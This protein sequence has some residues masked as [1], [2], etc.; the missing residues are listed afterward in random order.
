MLPVNNQNKL[1]TV[2]ASNQ[3]IINDI[4]AWYPE[5]LKQVKQSGFYKKFNYGSPIKD[6]HAVWLFLR[7]YI[8]YKKDPDEA[9]LLRLPGRFVNDRSGD[10]KSYS[11]FAAAVMGALGYK[12]GFRYAAYKDGAQNPTHVYIYLPNYDIII[13]GCYRFFNKEKEYKFVKNYIMNNY[14]LSGINSREERRE[15]RQE[16]RER[17]QER[18]EERQERREERKASGKPS[19]FKKI[20][21]AA[22]RN[23]FLLM[24]K[25]NVFGMA[26]KLKLAISKNEKAVKSKWNKLGGNFDKLKKQIEIGAKKKAIL[27]GKNTKLAKEQIEGI[28]EYVKT[29]RRGGHTYV[30]Y[31]NQ[32]N[33]LSDP[34][35]RQEL[36]QQIKRLIELRKSLTPGD[37]QITELTQKI[38]AMKDAVTGINIEPVSSVT[39]GSVV[40]AATPVL[41]AITGM[42]KSL[43][44]GQGKD[45]NDPNNIGLTDILDTAA[46][47][48][49][50]IGVDPSS[51][52]FKVD[53]AEPGA[54][55]I[56]PLFIIAPLALGAFFLFRKK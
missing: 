47:L 48:G 38:R 40:A 26:T 34:K 5:A 19:T 55:G 4:H 23:S 18:R 9:Q 53:D 12:V 16:R 50:N 14:V 15:R 51:D 41:V 56:N 33:G 24:V 28:G 6:A 44:I 32:L 35:A 30:Y 13:D 1:I 3:D 49:G 17:R 45:P 7:N 11:I 37:P 43:N 20:S 52:D 22:P 39:F 36:R 8:K 2:N 29:I 46:A 42:L 54:G 21:L 31:T 27:G 10:C 25:L